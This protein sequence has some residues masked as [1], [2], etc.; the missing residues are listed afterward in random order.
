MELPPV[1]HFK[2]FDAILMKFHG[3]QETQEI[4]NGGGRVRA[5]AT[6]GIHCDPE[7][8]HDGYPDLHLL[9]YSRLHL[10]FSGDS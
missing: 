8:D 1:L 3:I 2:D 9:L 6:L 5:N 4:V 10:R 7:M